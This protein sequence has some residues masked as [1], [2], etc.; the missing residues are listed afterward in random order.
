[1]VSVIERCAYSR[2]PKEMSLSL[3]LRFRR[4][5]AIG[6]TEAAGGGGGC[7]RTVSNLRLLLFLV[8]SVRFVIES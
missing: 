4:D 7:G 2:Q 6:P 1:M 5:R 8:L 3:S